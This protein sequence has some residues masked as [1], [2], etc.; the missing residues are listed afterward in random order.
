MSEGQPAWFG[1]RATW[2]RECPAG[3]ELFAGRA[4]AAGIIPLAGHRGTLRVVLV[5]FADEHHVPATERELTERWHASARR[6]SSGRLYAAEASARTRIERLQR[7]TAALAA[8]LDEEEVA[9]LIV[10]EGMAALG[11]IAG[12]LMLREDDGVRVLASTG[13]PTHVLVPG[14]APSARRAAPAGG[15]P[16][17]G[18]ALL[19]RVGGGLARELPA[20]R[21]GASSVAVGPSLSAHGALTGAIAF[22]FSEDERRFS[23]EEREHALA[24]AAQCSSALERA[25]L[26]H[27]EQ[28][29]REAA[30]Q[31][32]DRARLLAGVS[33]ALDAR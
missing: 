13:Y 22:R 8:T 1:D 7:M 14:P 12:V 2:R 23:A 10:S 16:A 33:L 15:R 32:E 18:R 27:A 29:A 11:A 20:R 19:V 5:V 28:R 4:S 21:G 6:R 17:D 24:L 9:R 26:H 31:A 25:R 30:E 3:A